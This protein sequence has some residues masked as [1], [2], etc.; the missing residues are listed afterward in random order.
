[1]E[2][3]LPQV[4]D[5][6]KIVKQLDFYQTETREAF[7]DVGPSGLNLACTVGGVDE[8]DPLCNQRLLALIEIDED[9]A[10]DDPLTTDDNQKFFIRVTRL[11]SEGDSNPTPEAF[12]GEFGSFHLH[13][14]IVT[15]PD[16][17]SG[18]ANAGYYHFKWL[19]GPDVLPGPGQ[20]KVDVVFFDGAKESVGLDLNDNFIHNTVVEVDD[21]GSNEGFNTSFIVTFVEEEEQ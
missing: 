21:F 17:M 20:Y 1:M 5:K 6:F 13:D 18:T 3:L 11:T 2:K 8:D 19:T 12:V 4:I 15:H 16:G 10:D 9:G 14:D 7:V